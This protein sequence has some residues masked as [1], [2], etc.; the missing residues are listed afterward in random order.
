[1]IEWKDVTSYRLGERGT[2]APDAW[3][4]NVGGLRISVVKGHVYNPGRWS[5]RCDPWFDVTDL[6]LSSDATGEEAKKAS[7]ERVRCQLQN[8]IDPISEALK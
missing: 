2:R 6:D 7:L 8:S 1:M 3:A 4:C 5:L